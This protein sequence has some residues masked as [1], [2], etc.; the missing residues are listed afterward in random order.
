MPTRKK[1]DTQLDRKLDILHRMMS[2]NL[3]LENPKLVQMQMTSITRCWG[4]LDL[5][6]KAFLDNCTIYVSEQNEWV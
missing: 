3:H 5:E 2:M 4:D 1:L 6:D